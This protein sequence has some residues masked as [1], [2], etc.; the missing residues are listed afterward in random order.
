MKSRRTHEFVT[1]FA[2]LPNPIKQLARKNYRLWKQ[3]PLHPGLQ[4][5]RVQAVEG[6]YSVRV[7]LDW[8]VLG[9]KDGETMTWFWIGP[10]AEYDRL[11]RTLR[12]T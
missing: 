2:K 8:R 1:R 9:V 4:F 3:N 5:K 12:N 11:L 7:G 6:V 10:H